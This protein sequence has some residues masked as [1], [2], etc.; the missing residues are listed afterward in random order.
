[1]STMSTARK[2]PSLLTQL[3]D[4]FLIEATNWR[5]S[6]RSMIVIGAAGPVL[7]ILGFSLFAR[8]AGPQAL[9]YVLTGNMV[10]S[11]MLGNMGSVQSHFSFMRFQGTLDYFATLPVR[12]AALILAVLVAFFLIHL[13]A[14]SLTL[15]LGWW[16]LKI[17]LHVHPLLLLTAPLCALPLSGIGALIGIQT[18]NP[19]NSGAISLLI[20]M[21]MSGLGPVIA[22]AERFPTLLAWL[23]WLNPAVYAASALRQTLVGPLTA[24]LWL[25]VAM[26]MGVSVVVLG[27]VGRR[28]DWRQG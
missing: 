21:V 7:S 27:L 23:G 2:R 13:P 11:L 16:V 25:D 10:I 24:R 28:L 12:R 5:W 18:D 26:L 6:W 9:A 19:Q 3:L 17:P 15:L 1:M 14:I 20:T 8:D 22:P 4:L